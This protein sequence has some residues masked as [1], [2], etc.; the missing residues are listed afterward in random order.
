MTLAGV[1]K[2]RGETTTIIHPHTTLSDEKLHKERGHHYECTIHIVHCQVKQQQKKK[3][4][5]L[6]YTYWQVGR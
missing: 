3:R 5:L 4:P 1:H 2:E 6:P